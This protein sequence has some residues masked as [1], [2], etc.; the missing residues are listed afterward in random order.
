MVRDWFQQG[1]FSRFVQNLESLD[2]IFFFRRVWKFIKDRIGQKQNKIFILSEIFCRFRDVVRVLQLAGTAY[3]FVLS[4]R[5]SLGADTSFSQCRLHTLVWQALVWT[6][7][8]WYVQQH[9]VPVLNTAQASQG[10]E[11]FDEIC[12]RLSIPYERCS[13]YSSWS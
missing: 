10:G 7:S 11:T 5:V 12:D 9:V 8:E 4:S 13:H 3:Y 6:V 1:G 2:T